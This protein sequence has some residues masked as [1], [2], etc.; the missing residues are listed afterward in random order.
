MTLYRVKSV[1]TSHRY[2]CEPIHLSVHK[3]AVAI[4][5]VKYC[6]DLSAAFLCLFL[7]LFI[8]GL[9]KK[10]K[11]KVLRLTETA[12][13]SANKH[14]TYCAY[15]YSL[16]RCFP[17]KEGS[18]PF[19]FLVPC[20]YLILSKSNHICWCFHDL[21]I[22]VVIDMLSVITASSPWWNTVPNAGMVLF[23]AGNVITL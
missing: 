21:S 19:D 13:S 7:S 2:T 14:T 12:H 11:K 17:Y 3:W 4:V 20:F 9:C 6:Y 16:L 15:Q 18:D 1:W 23:P 8:P 22:R 10:K 5:Y